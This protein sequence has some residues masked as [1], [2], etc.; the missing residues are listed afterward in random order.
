MAP[1]HLYLAA[2]VLGGVLLGASMLLDA[3]EPETPSAPE[4]GAEPRLAG[5][6]LNASSAGS[7]APL[8][9]PFRARGALARHLRVLPLGLIGFGLTGLLAKG[10]NVD[11][12]R[13]TILCALASGVFLTALGYALSR[14]RPR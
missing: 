12:G 10:L 14:T 13:W 2:W 3:R 5:G 4:H 6:A 9:A 11:L 8:V 1:I 7:H